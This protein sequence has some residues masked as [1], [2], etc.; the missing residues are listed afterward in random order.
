MIDSSV[1]LRQ[2]LLTS[3]DI[4]NAIGGIEK[5]IVVGELPE[6]ADPGAGQF[7]ITVR[8]RGGIPHKEVPTFGDSFEIVVWGAKN[9]IV[10]CRAI[11]GFIYDLAHGAVGVYVGSPLVGFIVNCFAHTTPQDLIDTATQWAMS[12]NYYDAQFRAD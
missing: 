1:T 7:W 10:Q 2:F 9:A 3:T 4:L 5:R 8:S 12:V 6:G 11:S